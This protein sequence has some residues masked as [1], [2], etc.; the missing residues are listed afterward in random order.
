MTLLS[1]SLAL[2]LIFYFRWDP[3]GLNPSKQVKPGAVQKK[4]IFPKKF[5]YPKQQPQ[6]QKLRFD[7]RQVRPQAVPADIS[8]IDVVP[9]ASPQRPLLTRP[10]N[11]RAAPVRPTA[12]VPPPGSPRQPVPQAAQSQ[13]IDLSGLAAGYSPP[14]D[15]TRT[16]NELFGASEKDAPRYE[17]L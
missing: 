17:Y 16:S 3:I 14:V 15:K 2:N 13:I 1:L 12:W 11:P 6:P 5:L 8:R 10:G 7:P 9:A 4:P